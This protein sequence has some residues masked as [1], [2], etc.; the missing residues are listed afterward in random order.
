MNIVPVP[1]IAFILVLGIAL[2][3][4][5]FPA[6]AAARSSTPD[7]RKYAGAE[8]SKVLADREIRNE[9]RAL[10]KSSYQRFADNFEVTEKL[11]TINPDGSFEITGFVSHLHMEYRSI[12]VLKPDGKTYAALL[13]VDKIEYF[14]NDL[15]YK[16]KLYPSIDV[17]RSDLAD[18]PVLFKSR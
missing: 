2:F 10:M 15:D 17:W 7:L 13:D 11:G 6:H 14:S 1:R 4:R 9:L 8:G 12:L 3:W 16:D 5:G 18:K